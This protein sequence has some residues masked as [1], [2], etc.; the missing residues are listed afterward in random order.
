MNSRQI[1]SRKIPSDRDKNDLPDIKYQ[2]IL[3]KQYHNKISKQSGIRCN[4]SNFILT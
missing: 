3:N 4:N 1:L 2:T